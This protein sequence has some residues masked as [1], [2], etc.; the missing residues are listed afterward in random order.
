MQFKHSEGVGH[1]WACGQHIGQDGHRTV[2]SLKKLLL[3][4]TAVKDPNVCV[5]VGIAAA[6]SLRVREEAG[7]GS[8][9]INTR[10]DHLHFSLSTCKML[11]LV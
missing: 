4:N 10:N 3:D 2:P 5:E 1:M 6:E 9:V 11:G 7:M 8:P